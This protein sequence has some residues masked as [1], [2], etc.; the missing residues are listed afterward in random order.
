MTGMSLSESHNRDIDYATALCH[1]AKV[2]RM[3]IDQRNG[4]ALDLPRAKH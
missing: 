1:Y 2:I 3:T 4:C